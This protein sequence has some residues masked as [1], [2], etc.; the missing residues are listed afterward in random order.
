MSFCRHANCIYNKG[1][2]IARRRRHLLAVREID[3]LLGRPQSRP[4]NSSSASKP[5]GT[6][7]SKCLFTSSSKHGKLVLDSGALRHIEVSR[8][9]LRNLHSCSPVLLQGINGD[10]FNIIE[11]GSCGHCHNV[12]LAP[13]ASASVRSVSALIDSHRVFILFTDNAAYILPPF[14][15]QDNKPVIIAKRKSDGLFHITPDS[16]PPASPTAEAHAYLSVPQQ[17]K[18]EAIHALHRI[19]GHAS[20]RRMRQALTNHPEL[21]TSL[22]PNDVRLFTHCDACEIGNSHRP[23]APEKADVRATAIGYCIH[24]DTSGTVR[25]HTSSGFTRVLI[26]VDDASRWIFISLLR[27]A[28]MGVIAA[29]MRAILRKVAGDHSVLRTKIIRT[30]NGKEFC[31]RLVDALLA[32]SDIQRELTC[33]GTSHQNGVAERAIGIVFAIA[34]TLIVDASLP[35]EFWG[36]AVITAVYLRNRLPCSANPGNI[37]PFEAR[38]GR[39]PDLRHLRPFGVSAFVRI[40]KHLTKVQARAVK[41]TFI[42]YGESVSA[43]KGWRIYMPQTK[44]VITTTAV[45]FSNDLPSSVSSRDPSLLSSRPPIFVPED[46][47]PLPAPRTNL[48]VSLQLPR[49]PSAPVANRPPATSRSSSTSL[50]PVTSTP[51]STPTPSATAKPL[52]SP[53]TTRPPAT[54]PPLI[55][56]PV[57]P[58][59]DDPQATQVAT[60]RRPLGRPPRNSW[61]DPRKGRY[62]SSATALITNYHRVW[63]NVADSTPSPACPTTYKQATTGP[64]SSKW[65][66]AIKS[67]LDSLHEC[68]AWAPIP[69]S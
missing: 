18:R 68:K 55:T 46:E 14:S 10:S 23:A 35:A 63:C 31:N 48:P 2:L 42:G 16:V 27:N 51:V 6:I 40:Q 33:V 52:P 7:N 54:S 38:Y 30:D 47:Q 59:P 3:S 50:P 41:G 21:N 58:D 5:Q 1:D 19:L 24:L 25:P 60:V 44:R 65:K 66:V 62:V 53:R 56:H 20:T 36:E 22:T 69:R 49:P 43:Q 37:S 13:K 11:E 26:A 8:S 64:D 45:T 9:R 4:P 34:R 28:S 12:L 32:E 29:A 39:R 17:I 15:L 67:E 57:F 61:W